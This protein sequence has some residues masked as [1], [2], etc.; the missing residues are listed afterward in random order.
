[1]LVWQLLLAGPLAAVGVLTARGGWLAVRGRLPVAES[2]DHARAVDPVARAAGLAVAV[3]GV[4]AVVGAAVTWVQPTLPAMFTV[5]VIT[6]AGAIGLTVA[7]RRLSLLA[8]V[9]TPDA[10]PAATRC[11]ACP[12]T[13]T[14]GRERCAA[15]DP[16]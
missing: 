16:R 1:M 6:W 9:T 11:A 15:H 5:A 3:A 2:R 8:T 12:L 10:A 13:C 14:E 7:A 4:L